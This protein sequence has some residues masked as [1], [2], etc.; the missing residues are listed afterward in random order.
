M[1]LTKHPEIDVGKA[2]EGNRLSLGAAEELG[3]ADQVEQHTE[4][5]AQ[6][7]TTLRISGEHEATRLELGDGRHA[8][9]T[10]DDSRDPAPPTE[11]D[12]VPIPL[13]GT[14]NGDG[15]ACIP[16]ALHENGERSA[17]AVTVTKGM[18]PLRIYVSEARIWQAVAG[19]APDSS[20]IPRLDFMLLSIIAAHREK[21]VLQPDLTRISGQDKRSTPLRTQRL[22]D[23]GYIEK[24]KVQLRGQSTSLCTLR[25]FTV[26][27]SYITSGQGEVVEEGSREYNVATRKGEPIVD[28][29]VLV[30][31]IFRI[32]G[33]CKLITHV[34]LRRKLV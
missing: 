6:S 5:S 18:R 8:V 22:H 30:R 26:A 11:D 23:R 24:R 28:I 3:K 29:A 27:P 1:W 12:Q 17:I 34:D 20:R 32:L 2:K 10:A 33:Q 25:K 31:D 4:N 15:S 13:A 7:T 16:A 9:R 19:H 21:G 14:E